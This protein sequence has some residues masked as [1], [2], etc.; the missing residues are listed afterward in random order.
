MRYFKTLFFVCTLS[1]VFAAYAGDTSQNNTTTKKVNT[2]KT[3][4][5]TKKKTVATPTKPVSR[6]TLKGNWSKIKDMFM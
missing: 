6:G 4:A 3:T 1:L 5:T 2:V